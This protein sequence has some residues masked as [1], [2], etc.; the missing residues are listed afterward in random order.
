MLK[1]IERINQ[2]IPQIKIVPIMDSSEYIQRSINNVGS[3]AVYG[4]AAGHPGILLL[5][6]RNIR[7]T[8]IIATAIPISIIATFA[9]MYFGASP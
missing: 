2:D 8:P 4:G 7:S 9:L 3:S 6:L 1:E 5:F